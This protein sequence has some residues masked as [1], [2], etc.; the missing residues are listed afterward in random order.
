[1]VDFEK[2]FESIQWPFMLKC[3]DFGNNCR[4]W[5]KIL[6]TDIQS[7]VSNNGHF[8]QYFNL[9]CAIRQG[10]PISAL[11]FILVA[12]I[13]TIKIRDDKFIKGIKVKMKSINYVN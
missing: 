1:M 9:S 7:C 2:A 5:I 13:L 12:E 8:S 6:Y 11:L 10:C 3:L 4:K